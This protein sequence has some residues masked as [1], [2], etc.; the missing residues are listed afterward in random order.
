MF[1][2]KVVLIAFLMIFPS[3][4]MAA[5]GSVINVIDGDSVVIKVNGEQ[6]KADLIFV[7]AP[8][9]GE[10]Y[11]DEA[12]KYVVERIKGKELN[13]YDHGK[14]FKNNH[15]V[16]VF[17]PTGVSINALLI[18][19][20]YARYYTSIKSSDKLMDLEKQAKAKKIG[21]WGLDN[22]GSEILYSDDRDEVLSHEGKAYYI[23]KDKKYITKQQ[24]KELIEEEKR[25]PK[26]AVEKRKGSSKKAT[27]NDEDVEMS[28]CKAQCRSTFPYNNMARSACMSLCLY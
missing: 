11:G 3:V 2:S 17:L 28:P 22:T 8:E 14:F 9:L 15:L 23:T 4:L 12:K 6:F 1:K 7:D 10:K 5:T 18:K 27:S 26:V 16:E 13:I 20:G 21:V 25:Q 19:N 24:L